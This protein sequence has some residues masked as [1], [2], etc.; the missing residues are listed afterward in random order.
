MEPVPGTV[1]QSG[2]SALKQV[3]IKWNRNLLW[4]VDLVAFSAPKMLYAESVGS[5]ADSSASAAM[6][7]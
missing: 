7:R 5:D 3:P 6:S 2:R 1:S 4:I